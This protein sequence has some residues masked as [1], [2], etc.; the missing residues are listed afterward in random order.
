[1]AT[2]TNKSNQPK[3]LKSIAIAGCGG[4]GGFVIANLYNY[5]AVRDQFPYTSLQVDLFDDDI[6][7]L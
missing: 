4:I 3:E 7:K 5:G 1:M 2:K 6:V